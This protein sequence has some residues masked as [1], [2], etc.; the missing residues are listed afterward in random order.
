MER[1]PVQQTFVPKTRPDMK[2]Q[3]RLLKLMCYNRKVRLGLNSLG[4]VSLTPKHFFHRIL[5][6]DQ[7]IRIFGGAV[8]M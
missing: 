4:P 5:L 1:P 3:I 6:F 2:V 7:R 8:V